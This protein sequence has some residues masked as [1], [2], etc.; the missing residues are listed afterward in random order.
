MRKILLSLTL[1]C[2]A[3]GLMGRDI[4][5]VVSDPEGPL[6]GAEVTVQGSDDM[7]ITD[8]KGAFTISAETGDVL[9]ISFMGMKDQTVKVDSRSSYTI[10][11]APDATEIDAVDV[12]R[13]YGK[14]NKSDRTGSTVALEASSLTKSPTASVETALA[15]KLSGVRVSSSSGQPG[16]SSNIQIRGLGSLT[17]SNDPL[18]VVDGMPINGGGRTSSN[19]NPLASI[20][21]NDILSMEVLKDA[22]ATA[23]YGARAA[24][25]VVMI[26]TK[27]G[28]TTKNEESSTISY[29]GQFSVASVSDKLDLM[30]LHDFATYYTDPY[31]AAAYNQSVDKELVA[32]AQFGGQGTDWQDEMFRTA[33]SHSHQV[34]LTGG[35]QKTQYAL[36]LGYMNQDGILVNTD[37]ERFNGRLNLENQVK[38]WLRI[39]L[40]M[41]YTHLTQTKQN[42]FD[43]PDD[44]KLSGI[45]SGSANEE[46]V[47]VQSLIS[48]PA[49]SP[50]DFN[51]DYTELGAEDQEIKMNPL[52]E[53]N[54]SPIYLKKNNVMGQTFLS[55][56]LM[57]D[58]NWTNSFGMDYSSAGESRYTPAQGLGTNQQEFIDRENMYYRFCST[59]NYNLPQPK[60]SK[61]KFNALLGYEA[62]KATWN[63]TS[64]RKNNYLDNLKFIDKDYQNTNLGNAEGLIS[65]YKG[66][67]SMMSTFARVHYTFDRRYLITATG[68]FDG[69]STLAPE[70]RW[71]FFPSFSLAW[72]ADQELF[73]KRITS[74]QKITQLKLRAG[75]GQTGNAGNNMGY[76]GSYKSV[77]TQYGA[78]K[79][80]GTWLNPDLI[81][82][83]NWQVNAGLDASF[84]KNRL[85]LVFDAF[86][87][88]NNDLI[89]KAEPGPTLASTVNSYMYT[90]VPDINAG[91]IKNVGFDVTLSSTNIRK[92]N[93]GGQP[94]SWN[95][96][97]NF[98]FVR[99]EVVKLQS[100]SAVLE[101]KQSFKTATRTYCVSRVGHAPGLFWGYKTDGLIQNSEQLAELQRADA[102]DVGDFNFVDVNGDGKINEDDKTYIGDPNPDFTFG[103]GNTFNWGPWSLNVFLTGSYGN[104]VYNLLRSK[105]E[106][107]DRGGINQLKTVLNCAR[108]VTNEDGS[109]YISNSSTNIPRPN[110]VAEGRNV[111]NVVSDRYVEDASYIRIQSIGLSY[112]VPSEAV[113]K[114]GLNNMSVSFSVQNVATFTKYSG[115]NPEVPSVSAINQGV[116]TGSYPL[117]RSYVLGLNFDF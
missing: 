27:R 70:N 71:G 111:A 26:T 45:G 58:L 59:L 109:K 33:I 104:D 3:G 79:V 18:Y 83:T 69:S 89:V 68:R 54:Y 22:S 21:P 88:K 29:A 107:M 24:N 32:L 117:S 14:M 97:L 4:T 113:K 1:L 2:T 53:A 73:M 38:S 110:S 116:D 77:N 63:G 6:P 15:G 19:D 86:Y 80:Y 49:T 78:G 82:E 42:G 65:G 20:N 106:G 98:S 28:N 52:R 64:T 100:D 13:D 9:V 55:I 112:S 46:A 103:F 94:F 41:A 92:D 101:G 67:Q 91:S 11:M 12:V 62:W 23:I 115:L 17:G 43:F 30:D 44:N 51:G 105:L 99:N 85:N 5:G 31:V 61:H 60:E 25:G 8:E 39:G 56:N 34:S 50:V 108:V 35:T 95:S 87:K 93:L 16:Q 10:K 90:S 7:E 114:I 76:I 40:N 57:K 75:W 81:W 72:N 37:F 74:K 102:T 48:S 96:D 84:F 36:S 66:A 47:Y